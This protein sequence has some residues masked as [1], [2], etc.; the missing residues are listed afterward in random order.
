L[1]EFISDKIDPKQFGG[2]KGNSITHYLI[3][4]INFI[5]YNQ[6]MT[7]P[8]AVLA[9]MVD[10]SKAFNRQN[11]HTLIT[12]LSDMGV[13]RWLLEI[14]I[15]FLS[16]RELIVRHKGLKSDTKNLPGGSPQGTRLGMFLF[17]VLINFAGFPAQDISV[18]IGDEI[19][20][21]KN[22]RKP[23]LN[24]H[25]KYIDDLTFAAAINLKEKLIVIPD[26]DVPLPLSFQERTRHLL[27]YEDNVIQ[28]QFDKL[29]TFANDQQMVINEQKTKAILFNSGINH[30]FLPQIE[31]EAGEMLEVV[32]EVKLLG[33]VV[34]S[35][36]KW[37]SNTK[38]LSEKGYNRLWMLRNLKKLGACRSDLIDV[39]YKQCRSVLELAVPAWAPGLT[40]TEANQLERI[41]KSACAI[42]LG[43]RYTSYKSAI[44]KLNM[45]TL[46]SRRNDICLTFA[47]KAVNSDKFKHWFSV[48]KETEPAIKTRNFKPKPKLKPV[49]CRTR[50]YRNSPLPYLT[51]ILNQDFEKHSGNQQ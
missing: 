17:L 21:L 31:T 36:M 15:A 37:H 43:E 7:K 25:L 6:D 12:I 34:R 45:Q 50:K 29:K 42:I 44:N 48:E 30:D 22:K 27:P 19:T 40:K 32:E 49:K 46:E 4:F 35:D 2:Q 8:H 13:P 10:F 20:K 11:H 41:Q 51:N 28:Q 16:E 23:L 47:K 26:P 39:Y 18:N 1:L 33:I 14:V 3:E 9:L 5:L 24:T 38:L